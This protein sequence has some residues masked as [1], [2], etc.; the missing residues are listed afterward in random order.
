MSRTDNVNS[1]LTLDLYLWPVGKEHGMSSRGFG[2]I[3]TSQW[4]KVILN[5]TALSN[6][7]IAFKDSFE[8]VVKT[9]KWVKQAWTT[10]QV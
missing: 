8:R 9:G 1:K 10:C 2:S 7:V 3:N 5:N 4:S 6:L